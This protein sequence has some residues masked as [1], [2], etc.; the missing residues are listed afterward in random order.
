MKGRKAL[1]KQH[2]QLQTLLDKVV[3]EQ[4]AEE[5]DDESGHEERQAEDN[6]D[7]CEDLGPP[8][9]RT[10]QLVPVSSNESDIDLSG[11]LQRL[12]PS[13]PPSA[14]APSTVPTS[15]TAVPFGDVASTTA[16]PIGDVA[17]IGDMVG[18]A[19]MDALCAVAAKVDPPSVRAAALRKKPAAATGVADVD[20]LVRKYDPSLLPD[21]N[22]SILKKRVYSSAYHQEETRG[23]ALQLTKDQL[24]QR[25]REW[26]M[27]VCRKWEAAFGVE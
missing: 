5:S 12:F 14:K 13:S 6:D 2:A 10:R 22:M 15:S 20:A 16:V 9:K 25:A 17:V 7:S 11:L 18:D 27:L 24:K 3:I 21:V 23:K 8:P 19:E 26:G 1:P 4:S